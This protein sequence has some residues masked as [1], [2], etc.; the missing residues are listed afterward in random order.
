M[1]IVLNPREYFVIVRQ[2]QDHTDSS[3]YYVRALVR[4]S[5]TDEI[6][7]T[8]DLDD[9]GNRRFVKQY[10]VP[11]DVSGLGLFIDITSSV[12]T[13]SEYTTKSGN[14]GD[15][16]ET[17]LVS[18]RM[19]S[20]IGS[21]GGGSDVDYK[22]IKKMLTEAINSIKFPKITIPEYPEFPEIPKTDL[23]GVLDQIDSVKQLIASRPEPK[24]T[25][26]DTVIEAIEESSDRL[27]DAMYALPDT[28]IDPI[29]EAIKGMDASESMKILQEVAQRLQTD[30][31]QMSE[32]SDSFKKQLQEFTYVASGQRGIEPK[33]KEDP[34]ERARRLMVN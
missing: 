2:L 34:G 27:I 30:M 15:E 21:G 24:E 6:L 25:N 7:Q 22:K 23:T 3:T 17:Y 13:D 12:Y 18:D 31:P 32:W 16:N 4:N 1:G 8:I 20:G 11:A 10:Q 14:Y 26:L 28:D 9:K 29:L 33:Q 19:R 5:R